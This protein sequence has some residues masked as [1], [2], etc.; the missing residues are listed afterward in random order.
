MKLRG[1]YERHYSFMDDFAFPAFWS[2]E[3][4]WKWIEENNEY[5]QDAVESIWEYLLEEEIIES[6]EYGYHEGNKYYYR[7]EDG[8]IS[9]IERNEFLDFVRKN[10]RVEEVE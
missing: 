9:W 7:D 10:L 4:A 1:A 2:E 8:G 6:D 3:D 5:G